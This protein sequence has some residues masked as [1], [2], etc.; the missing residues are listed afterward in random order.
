MRMHTRLVLGFVLA[1]ALVTMAMG[2]P[3]SKPAAGAEA[4]RLIGIKIY[5]HAGDFRQ[6][7]EEWRAIGI[8]TAFVS[9]AL[10]SKP[11]FRKLAR[12]TGTA[13]YLILPIFFNAEELKKRPDLAAVTKDGK[14]ASEDWVKFIC[15]SREGYR[16]RVEGN[17]VRLVKD[18]DPDG[19]SLD[20]IRHF[21]FWEKVY[22]DRTLDSLPNSC[23]DQACLEKFQRDTKIS[24]P[25]DLTTAAARAGWILKNHLAAWTDWKCALIAG[26]VKDLADAARTIKPGIKVNIHSVPWRAKDFGGGIRIVAGQDLA[27]MTASS[28]YV[29]PMCYHHMVKQTPA[30]VHSVVQDLAARVRVPILPSIQVKEAYIPE[31]LTVAEFKEALIEALKPPSRGVVFWSWDSLSSDQERK[32]V[33]KALCGG[34]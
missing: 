7:F 34:K 1:A 6:L 17:I 5:D 20:F 13:V 21:V 25:G 26:V 32:A 27:A 30:W 22:P 24:I 4:D 10:A 18:L 14:P 12:E 2:A 8:N 16:R 29:S 19:I 31:K 33:V 9:P 15:P 3:R 23:F 28:D 11:G